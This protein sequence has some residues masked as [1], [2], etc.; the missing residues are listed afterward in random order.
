MKNK[1]RA[2]RRHHLDRVKKKRKHYW[3]GNAGADPRSAGL[4]LGTP[5]LCSCW[6]CGNQRKYHGLTI[7]E[8]KSIGDQVE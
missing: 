6:M 4:C 7:Q 5:C 1:Q 8:R 3:H 2:L